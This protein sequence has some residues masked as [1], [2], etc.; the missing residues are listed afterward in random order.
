MRYIDHILQRL[1]YIGRESAVIKE[2]QTRLHEDLSILYDMM[3]ED[4]QKGRTKEQFHA[5]KTV[6][7]WT[8]YAV[9]PLTIKEASE[10]VALSIAD[11]S[12]L[13]IEEELIG[14]SSRYSK[15]QSGPHPV[16]IPYSDMLTNLVQN[17]GGS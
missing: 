14:K 11:R 10:V 8:A 5:L 3:L 4:C 7:I 9:R 17:P 6:F 2:L 16:P 12:S 15:T 13:D 1:S